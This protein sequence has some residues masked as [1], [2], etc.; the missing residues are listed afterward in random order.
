MHR[1]PPMEVLGPMLA[2]M[3]RMGIVLTTVLIVMTTVLTGMVLIALTGTVLTGTAH[4][5]SRDQRAMAHFQSGTAHFQV[6]DY[7]AALEAYTAAYELTDQP[8]L[9]YNIYLCH[10]RL[11]DLEQSERWLSRYLAEEPETPERE[12]LEARLQ[13]MR[14]R[15]AEGADDVAA[16]PTQAARL[17]PT[18]P[19]PTPQRTETQTVFEVPAG[20]TVAYVVGGAALLAFAGVGTAALVEDARLEGDC[21]G[22]CDSQEVDHLESLVIGADVLAAVAG[23]GALVGLIWMIVD[24]P[25]T[26]P[27]RSTSQVRVAPWVTQSGAGCAA[28]SHF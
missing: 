28:L 18:V 21:D 9:M 23:G 3:V 27:A 20:A 15:L 7:E 14:R 24:G 12:N 13:T 4:A 26:V 22:M 17:E 6:A 1:C 19:E 11:G 25:R 8:A 10:E 16:E 5:Q 2:G